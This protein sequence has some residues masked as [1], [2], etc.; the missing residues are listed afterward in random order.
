MQIVN[1]FIMHR[2]VF[3]YQS[4]REIFQIHGFVTQKIMGAGYIPFI[5]HIYKFLSLIELRHQFLLLKAG[6][7]TRDIESG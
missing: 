5:R 7:L 3:T 6:K 2:R 1:P 4:L